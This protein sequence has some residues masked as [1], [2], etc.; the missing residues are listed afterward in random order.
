MQVQVT[1]LT[2]LALGLVAAD[3]LGRAAQ[4]TRP[5]RPGAGDLA[6]DLGR[7]GLSLKHQQYRGLIDKD[8]WQSV[9]RVPE[10]ARFRR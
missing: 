6:L 8:R 3:W 4:H 1:M 10:A 5:S 9:V 7:I 2:V